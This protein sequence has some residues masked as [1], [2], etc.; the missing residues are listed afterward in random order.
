MKHCVLIGRFKQR[1][2]PVKHALYIC[3]ALCLLSYANLY[4]FHRNYLY[5][6]QPDRLARG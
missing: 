6:K 2:S 1:E 3:I 5:M 4:D